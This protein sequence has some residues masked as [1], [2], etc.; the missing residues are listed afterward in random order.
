METPNVIPV[1]GMVWYRFEDYDH[2][3]QIMEDRATL[4]GTYSKWRVQA[5]QNERQ[6]RRRGYSVV[7]VE[8]DPKTFLAWCAER[9][10]RVDSKARM[11]FANAGAHKAHQDL[12][13]ASS[14][15]A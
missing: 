3:L 5:E 8:I 4:P 7:R 15:N 12:G 14:G 6:T 2:I 9:G 13:N 1:A 11:E 10:L